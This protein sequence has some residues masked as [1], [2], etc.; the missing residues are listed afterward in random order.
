MNIDEVHQLRKKTSCL[1]DAEAVRMISC[2]ALEYA[3]PVGAKLND[4]LWWRCCILPCND[5]KSKLITVD[6]P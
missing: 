6:S 5:E 1:S 4:F 2:K 3:Q